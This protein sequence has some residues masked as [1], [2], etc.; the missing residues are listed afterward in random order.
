MS[1]LHQNMFKEDPLKRLERY[2]S[3]AE[4]ISEVVLQEES[5]FTGKYGKERT[6]VLLASVALNESN[7]DENIDKGIKRG[8]LGEVCIMQ[9]MPGM[10]DT[11][12]NYSAKYLLEDRKNCIRAA[13]DIMRGSDCG[14]SIDHRLRGY[15]SGKCSKQSNKKSEAEIRKTARNEVAGYYRFMYKYDPTKFT[16]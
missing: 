4:D 16:K 13:L 7:F 10:K 9:V 2:Q 6:A 12:Y 14:G 11:K 15:A 1:P 5:F 8:K 3:I